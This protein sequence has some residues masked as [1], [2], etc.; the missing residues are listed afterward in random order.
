[1]RKLK[2]RKS[3]TKGKGKKGIRA[4]SNQFFQWKPKIAPKT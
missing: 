1:M 2:E 3:G 4:F